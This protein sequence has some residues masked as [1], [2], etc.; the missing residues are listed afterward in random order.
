MKALSVG[1]FGRSESG[2]SELRAREVLYAA[3]P[4]H[5]QS[6]PENVVNCSHLLSRCSNAGP[7]EVLE[8]VCSS[9][10]HAVYK[11]EEPPEHNG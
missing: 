1:S 5:R 2:A 8:A 9:L 7:R 10:R 6:T 11:H 4:T 3:P